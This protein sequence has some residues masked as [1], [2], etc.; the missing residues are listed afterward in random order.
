MRGAAVVD[1]LTGALGKHFLLQ[2]SLGVGKGQGPF[3]GSF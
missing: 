1:L 3:M 2:L